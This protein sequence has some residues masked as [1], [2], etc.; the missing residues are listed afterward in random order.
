[1]YVGFIRLKKFHIFEI[2]NTA[3]FSIFS[4][5][6]FS[7]WN[8]Q[9]ITHKLKCLFCTV[10]PVLNEGIEDNDERLKLS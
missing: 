3:I 10:K 7:F 6:K 4:A 1:M 5:T 9:H 8:S 2:L